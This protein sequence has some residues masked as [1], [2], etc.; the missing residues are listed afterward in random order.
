VDDKKNMEKRIN[1]C[2]MWIW[3]K[4]LRISWREKRTNAEVCEEIG[5][6]NEER[7][8]Q[9][10]LRRK[11]SFFRHVMRSSGMG[12]EMTLANGENKRKQGR[13]R[14]RWMDEIQER[15]E[16]NLVEL[17]DAISDKRRWRGV[18]MAIARAQRADST[19]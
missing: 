11:L 16:V 9:T 1:A 2:E 8:R 19:G 17:R 14:K 7:L 4:V 15:T 13:P 6:E 12:K 18:I 3:R 10:M 5:A